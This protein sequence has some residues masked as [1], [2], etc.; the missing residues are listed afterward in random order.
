MGFWNSHNSL[1]KGVIFIPYNDDIIARSVGAG[2]YPNAQEAA[3]LE[4]QNQTE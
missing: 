1:Y 4:A 3:I 2:S